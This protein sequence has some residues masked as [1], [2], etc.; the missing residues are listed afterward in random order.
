MKVILIHGR[1]KRQAGKGEAR[2]HSGERFQR[3]KWNSKSG[4]QREIADGRLS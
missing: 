4:N 2:K 1:G 3:R